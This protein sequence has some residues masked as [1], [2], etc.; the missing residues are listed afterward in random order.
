[1][2]SSEEYKEELKKVLRISG[3]PEDELEQASEEALRVLFQIMLE[4]GSANV[5]FS[6]VPISP[7]ELS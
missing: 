5:V 2:K 1:M 7:E 6:A 4:T 3:C